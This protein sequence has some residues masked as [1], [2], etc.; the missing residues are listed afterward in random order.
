MPAET[1]AKKPLGFGYLPLAGKKA[2]SVAVVT[3]AD[4]DHISAQRK[5]IIILLC[6]W[7]RN[8]SQ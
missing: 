5:D 3:A 1:I 6:S 8:T 4:G 2:G 7:S